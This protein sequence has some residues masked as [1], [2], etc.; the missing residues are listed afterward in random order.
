MTI[1]RM[2]C[3]ANGRS[4]SSGCRMAG[5]VLRHLRVR[6][7]KVRF[8]GRL[9]AAALVVFAAGL[10]TVIAVGPGTDKP[11]KADAHAPKNQSSKTEASLTGAEAGNSAHVGATVRMR[12][13]HFHPGTVIVKA[14]QAVRFVNDDDVVH[15]VYEDLGARSGEEPLFASD[16]IGLGRSF[17]FVAHNAGVIRYVCTLHPATM[18][19]KIVVTGDQA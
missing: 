12:G 3:T 16:R 15:T 10:A 19:G 14:G 1:A 17:R 18:H 6:R 4:R 5:N 8:V 11:E 2:I 13:L 7:T 9:V